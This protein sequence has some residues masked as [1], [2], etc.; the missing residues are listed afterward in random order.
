MRESASAAP[1]CSAGWRPSMRGKAET[2]RAPRARLGMGT[3]PRRPTLRRR[4]SGISADGWLSGRAAGDN[5]GGRQVGHCLHWAG[6]SSASAMRRIADDGGIEQPDGS[7][8]HPRTHTPDPH[9][10]FGPEEHQRRRPRYNRHLPPV[11]PA[12]LSMEWLAANSARQNKVQPGN[13]SMPISRQSEVASAALL[14]P[15]ASFPIIFC[16]RDSPY[17]H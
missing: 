9:R 16:S 2:L 1:A 4:R 11:G 3:S 5:P 17:R 15:N 13:G 6:L 8:L 12:I 14:S 7:F 10:P